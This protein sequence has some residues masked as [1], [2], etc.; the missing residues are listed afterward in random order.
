MRKL[1][2]SQSIKTVIHAPG[3]YDFALQNLFH[4]RFRAKHCVFEKLALSTDWGRRKSASFSCSKTE[5]EQNAGQND[6][7]PVGAA[8]AVG[9]EKIRGG[10]GDEGVAVEHGAHIEKRGERGRFGRSLG[11]RLGEI[12]VIQRSRPL[13]R[14]GVQARKAR[15]VPC[16]PCRRGGERGR[17]GARRPAR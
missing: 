5:K 17:T 12:A 7:F 10:E 4:A 3:F 14:C 11:G 8:F 9:E 15:R 1:S 6:A 2:P 16:R 13:C